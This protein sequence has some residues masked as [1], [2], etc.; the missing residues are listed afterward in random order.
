MRHTARSKVV[1]DLQ[2][3]CCTGVFGQDAGDRPGTPRNVPPAPTIV[4][5]TTRIRVL[6]I[7][8]PQQPA[9]GADLLVL[10]P[11]FLR[12]QKL[13]LYNRRTS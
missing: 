7:R 10:D 2:K 8:R 9:V 12:I 6:I 11:F 13:L 1:D 5:R 4:Q 3:K